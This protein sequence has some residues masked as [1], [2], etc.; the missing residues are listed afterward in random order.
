MQSGVSSKK[1]ITAY[2]LLPTAYFNFLPY[3]FYTYNFRDVLH[4]CPFNPHL[5]C[6][7]GTWAGTTITHKFYFNH[8]A[9][10]HINQF[11]IPPV[12]LQGWPYLIQNFF[13]PFPHQLF[14][15]KKKKQKKKI[16]ENGEKG[17]K[18]KKESDL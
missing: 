6:H 16:K 9:F 17:K 7:G 12:H 11:H 2:C 15:Y 14:S 4:Y 3:L 18:E 10:F 8:S 13:Y 1:T 5:E